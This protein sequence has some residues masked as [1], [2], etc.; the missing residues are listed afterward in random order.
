MSRQHDHR[1]PRQSE[2]CMDHFAIELSAHDPH[3]RVFDDMPGMS[4]AVVIFD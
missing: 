2:L 4:L 3:N 1:I